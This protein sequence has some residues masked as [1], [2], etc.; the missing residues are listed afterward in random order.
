MQDIGLETMTEVFQASLIK[1]SYTAV[2][3]KE[4]RQ[5]P[6]GMTD[7]NTTDIINRQETSLAVHLVNEFHVRL[8]N[9]LIEMLLFQCE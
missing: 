5:M 7:I 1:A 6:E 2:I 4:R 3:R 8:C 9:V